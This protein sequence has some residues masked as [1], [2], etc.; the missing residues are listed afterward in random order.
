[1]RGH[2]I[3]IVTAPTHSSYYVNDQDQVVLGAESMARMFFESDGYNF[4]DRDLMLAVKGPIATDVIKNFI[5][6]WD[7]NRSDDLRDVR[8]PVSFYLGKR[9]SEFARD[10]RARDYEGWSL[11]SEKNLCRFAEQMPNGEE[12]SME[13]LLVSLASK[14]QRKIL[15]SG[16]KFDA[17][18]PWFKASLARAGSGVDFKYL[19]NGWEGGDGELTLY[20]DELIRSHPTLAPLL[21]TLRN[22]DVDRIARKRA[23]TSAPLAGL[24]HVQLWSFFSFIHY[25]LALFDQQGVWVGSAN[26]DRDSVTG[27]DE[28][29]IFCMDKELSRK[30]GDTTEIDLS[31]SVPVNI[32]PVK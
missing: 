24:P 13:N 26:P 25:K 19:G 1:M 32:M 10:L 3:Q 6:V 21:R 7:K 4:L 2:Q 31:N 30:L 9:A 17:D 22:W 20:L 28:S 11:S 23:H 16:V 29:G 12:R 27:Y 18:S 8:A 14:S 15:L 5:S